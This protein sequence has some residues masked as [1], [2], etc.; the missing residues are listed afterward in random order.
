MGS[1]RY[2]RRLRAPN[3]WRP[4]LYPRGTSVGFQDYTQVGI[5]T[6]RRTSVDHNVRRSHYDIRWCH[7]GTTDKLAEKKSL[8]LNMPTVLLGL[9]ATVTLLRRTQP[10]KLSSRRQPRQI[11]EL[12]SNRSI[13]ISEGACSSL[14]RPAGQTKKRVEFTGVSRRSLFHDYI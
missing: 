11:T 5:E 10:G 9:F 13:G 6:V 12:W 2:H 1:P 8:G 3:S 4:V 7:Q 14:L